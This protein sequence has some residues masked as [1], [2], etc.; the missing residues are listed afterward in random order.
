[1]RPSRGGK[2]WENRDQTEC[3]EEGLEIRARGVQLSQVRFAAWAGIASGAAEGPLWGIEE[4]F[5]ART[6][7]ARFGSMNEPARAGGSGRLGQ[8][9][10]DEVMRGSA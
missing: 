5:R 2:S 8:R 3:L 4:P 7:S 9:I 1:M 6:L 10:F